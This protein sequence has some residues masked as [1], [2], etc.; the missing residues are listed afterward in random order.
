M[1]ISC[2]KTDASLSHRPRWLAYSALIV[3]LFT[4]NIALAELRTCAPLEGWHSGASKKAIVK[5]VRAAVTTGDAGY[6]APTDRVAVVDHDGTLW[7]ENPLVQLAFTDWRLR[8]MGAAQPAWAEKAPF[9]QMLEN[10]I[11]EERYSWADIM[12]AL[13]LTHSQISKAEFE[14]EVLT[15]LASEL[16]PTLGT[17]YLLTAYQPMRELL[18]YLTCQ[19]FRVF[20][21]SGGG[22]N[23][24][25]A[26]ASKLYGIP[27][28]RVIG[29]YGQNSLKSIDGQTVVF[30]ENAFDVFLEN[31]HKVLEIEQRI[32]KRPAIAIGNVG[33]GSD[34][35]M[36]QHSQGRAGPSLQLLLLHDDSDR[37]F[38]YGQDDARSLEAARSS[39]WYV[40]SMKREWRHIFPLR[41]GK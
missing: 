36:L 31:R 2:V 3:A 10:G 9:Q 20:I 22:I 6:I 39:G 29:S 26:F 11:E 16:H 18:D 34:V 7:A 24:M 4:S 13:K 8:R 14:E 23:F 15:F 35:E 27:E 28:D 33:S 12:A 25:R 1:A 5:F 41:S 30:R 37:E 17:S 38:A 21:V 40:V 19:G 32:G